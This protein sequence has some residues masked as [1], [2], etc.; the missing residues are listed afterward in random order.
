MSGQYDVEGGTVKGTTEQESEIDESVYDRCHRFKL[1]CSKL[2]R[3]D[4]NPVVTLASA[5]IIWGLVIF[6]MVKPDT[7]SYFFMFVIL[8]FIQASLV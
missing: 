1:T 7:V 5:L 8:T 2:L 3:I 4:L 6:C